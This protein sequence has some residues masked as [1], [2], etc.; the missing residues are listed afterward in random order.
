MN[1]TIKNVL[2]RV[3]KYLL[4]II[5]IP[6]V[7]GALGYFVQGNKAE[8]ASATA[9]IKIE[10]GSYK[11]APQFTDSA[12][13]RETITKIVYENFEDLTDE[14]VT[15]I[16]SKINVEPISQG[17]ISLSFTGKDEEEAKEILGK[18]SDQFLALDKKEFQIRKD[19]AKG[20]IEKLQAE[21][22]SDE[23]SVVLEDTASKQR[24]I[25]EIEK[26]LVLMKE[27][28]VL[29]ELSV[30]PNSA[31]DLSPKKRAVLGVLIGLTIMAGFIIIPEVFRRN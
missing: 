23:G 21:N 24:L 4:F 9:T 10:L 7:L 30:T 26:E 17:M 2:L 13:V 5:I 3:R 20:K 31:E 18:I 14:E 25:Y 1:S 22:V 28:N 6:L 29:R 11:D 27:A 12:T 15:S 8:P 16:N 19:N